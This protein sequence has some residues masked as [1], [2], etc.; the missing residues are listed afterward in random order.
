MPVP[1]DIIGILVPRQRAK[2]KATRPGATLPCHE[3]PSHE[4]IVFVTTRCI[5]L[6]VTRADVVHAGWP[7]G[8]NCHAC[9]QESESCEGIIT[10]QVQYASRGIHHLPLLRHT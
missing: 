4:R 2:L 9:G 6:A 3:H 5:R 10:M 7:A 1:Y 8:L